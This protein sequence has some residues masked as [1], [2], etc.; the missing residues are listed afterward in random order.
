ME[1]SSALARKHT[2]C[3]A[4]VES[5]A[6]HP[7]AMSAEVVWKATASEFDSGTHEDE[8]EVVEGVSLT[9]GMVRK[10]YVTTSTLV[11]VPPPYLPP[12]FTL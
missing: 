10:P 7:S 3:I 1:E 8:F 5:D 2:P 9:K 6:T 12:S 4:F 11:E